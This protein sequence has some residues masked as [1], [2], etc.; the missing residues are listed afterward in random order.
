V[1]VDL[2]VGW[3]S[4]PVA[5]R[6]VL[7]VEDDD[8]VREALSMVLHRAGHFVLPVVSA[9]DAIEALSFVPFDMVLSDVVLPHGSGFDVIAHARRMRPG[10]PVALMSSFVAEDLAL[11]PDAADAFLRKPVP[12]SRVLELVG[13]LGQRRVADA[14]EPLPIRRPAHSR[15][16]TAM[17]TV[18]GL[19]RLISMRDRYTLEHSRRVRR[20]SGRLARAMGLPAE[21]AKEISLAAWVHDVGKISVPYTILNKSGLLTPD[22]LALMR[23][24]AAAGA[25]IL[26]SLGMPTQVVETVRHHHERYDG[27]RNSRYA[28]YPD[29][30][31]GEQIPLAARILTVVDAF[32]AMTTPRCYRHAVSVPSA[33]E[34]IRQVSGL[35]FDPNVARVF[36]EMVTNQLTHQL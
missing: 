20:L 17:D 23:S 28:A 2:L 12:A 35:H 36:L 11:A 27:D 26:A 14:D 32:D 31:A 25:A 34:E 24:H 6:R 21:Q 19:L 4:I 30:L 7:L 29:G 13:S 8:E 5:A 9:P 33:L 1:E 3:K 16:Y 18:R 22:E 10:L 15:L